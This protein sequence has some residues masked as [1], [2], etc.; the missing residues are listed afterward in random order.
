V[1]ALSLPAA[2]PWLKISEAVEFLRAV[3]PLRAVPIHQGIVNP[4]AYN[5]Y[6]QRY[7][8]MGRAD[9]RVLEPE[10]ATEF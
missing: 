5:L 4:I 8:E 10:A 2:A 1:A 3:N 9:F 6:Y 7:V